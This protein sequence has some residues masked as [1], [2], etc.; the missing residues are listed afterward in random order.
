MMAAP[1]RRVQKGPARPIVHLF[2]HRTFNAFIMLGSSSSGAGMDIEHISPDTYRLMMQLASRQDF[3]T[4][5]LTN[6]LSH[7][8]RHVR[9]LGPVTRVTKGV[10]RRQIQEAGR[11]VPIVPNNP[12]RVRRLVSRP[13]YKSF[14]D[15]QVKCVQALHDG[16]VAVR[17]L[18]GIQRKTLDDA[19][20]F[21]ADQM[22]DF[23]NQFRA[24][25]HAN[26]S[27]ARGEEELFIGGLSAEMRSG[28]RYAILKLALTAL[29]NGMSCVC[30][31]HSTKTLP[32]ERQYE[33]I[34]ED[35]LQMGFVLDGN[36]RDLRLMN[37]HDKDIKNVLTD[38][39]TPTIVI[40]NLDFYRTDAMAGPMGGMT[41]EVRESVGK[42]F[43]FV[44]DEFQRFF[45]HRG[46]GYKV[47]HRLS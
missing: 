18:D 34:R 35:L 33:E 30:W 38:T 24:V 6:F 31:V 15:I 46:E 40:A 20:P 9:P 42:G 22:N 36:V 45:T 11:G 25:H 28:K 8:R 26:Q 43:L 1:N 17:S 44:V 4:N 5:V 10:T 16:T 23:C 27:A 41:P 47:C 37:S 13:R 32:V 7:A 29:S 3:S 12:P 14:A 39:K 19:I 21:D 2:Y